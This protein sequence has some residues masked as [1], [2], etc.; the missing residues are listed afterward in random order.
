MYN[1]FF[2]LTEKP[3]EVTPDPK[4]LYMT[5]AYQEILSALIYGIHERRGFIAIVGEVGTGKTMMINALL[6]RLEHHTKVAFIFN[7][8]LTFQQM[9]TMALCDLGLAN[10]DEKLSKVEAIQRLNDYAIA[11]LEKGGNVVIIIDEAQ[12]LNHK[13]MENLRML[14]NLETRKHKLV[15]IILSGQ[16]ELDTKLNLPDWRQ[17]V[18][19]ISLK[20]YS[21]NLSEPDSYG[22]IQHRLEV[23]GYRGAPLFSPEALQMIWEYSEG[24]PRK[25]NILCD[26]ALLIGYGLEE[27]TIGAEIIAEAIRD[28]SWSPFLDNPGSPYARA[29]NTHPI[30][31]EQAAPAAQTQ[32]AAQPAETL[33]PPA[34]EI[35][36]PNGHKFAD[37]DAVELKISPTDGHQTPLVVDLQALAW[38]HSAK[39]QGIEIQSPD[40]VPG[41]GD[42]FVH[43]GILKNMANRIRFS[44]IA[45]ILLLL[46]FI[47]G[48]WLLFVKSEIS[49]G[50]YV[51][52]SQEMVRTEATELLNHLPDRTTGQTEPQMVEDPKASLK[53]VPQAKMR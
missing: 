26:N 21:M 30:L 37:P 40:E 16:P 23:A 42:V 18:Q 53:N 2:G 7:S 22:Y 24:I 33:L 52:S 46:C 19:R 48:A 41:H 15:Q 35:Q 43:Q 34:A 5:R 1:K 36:S 13:T 32:P 50:Q 45:G 6:D 11:Q 29:G 25:I 44:L 38:E 12:S 4:F 17:L 20:R 51:F 9:L 31:L 47:I 28:L 39:P 10:A 27:K 8:D 3:F 14:S 49:L